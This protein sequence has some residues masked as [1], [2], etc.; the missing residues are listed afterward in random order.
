MQPKSTTDYKQFKILTSNRRVSKAHVRTLLRSMESHPDLFQYRPILINKNMFIIDGQHRFTAAQQLGVPV[1]YVEAPD[2]TI[3][4]TQAMNQNQRNWTPLDFARSFAAV[5][6]KDY[7]TYIKFREDYPHFEHAV[8]HNILTG[9]YSGSTAKGGIAG[10]FKT[11]EF[12]VSE[13]LEEASNLADQLE[14]LFEIVYPKV[15]GRSATLLTALL[16]MMRNPDYD[17]DQ[18]VKHLKEQQDIKYRPNTKEYLR[19]MEDVYNFNMKINR[20]RFF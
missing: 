3:A 10:R 8:T 16:R 1:W 5:G 18:M 12:K 4:D 15:G 13:D 6:N 9:V 20:L 2:M 17:Q 19:D 7:Q 11:G 14:E